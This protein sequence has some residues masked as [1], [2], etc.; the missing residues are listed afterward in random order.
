MRVFPAPALV[1]V[2]SVIAASA[3]AQQLHYPPAARGDVVDDY[4]GHH[5]ADPYRWLE[6]LDAPATKAWVEAENTLTFG[7]LA[8]LPQRDSI[9]AR[10]TALWNYPKVGVPNREAGQIWFRKNTGLQRQSVLYRAATLG[11]T[12]QVALDPNLLSPDGSIA[13]AQTSPSPDG[14]LLGYTTAV[15]GSDLQDIHLRDLATGRDLPDVVQRVKFTGI[16]WTRDGKGF[17]YARF[18]SAAQGEA[19]REA[20]THHQLWYHTVGGGPDRLVFERPDDSTAFVGGGVSDDGRWLFIFSASGTSNNRLWLEDLKDPMH[21]ALDAAPRSIVTAED[22]ANSPLGIVGDTL[23]LYTNWLA[24]R[25]RIVAVAVGDTD[26]TH[27]RTVVAQGPDVMNA[28]A[29]VGNRLVVSDLVDVQSRIRLYDLSGAPKGEVSLPD[30][31]SVGGLS[32]RTDGSD[33][34]FSFSS[35]LRPTTVYRY[36][37]RSGGLTPFEAVHTPFDPSPYETRA[38][39]Y[40]SKDGTRIPIFITA[41]RGLVKDGNHPTLLYA[42]G[43]FD[44]SITPFFSPRVAAWLQLGG[45]YAVANIRG[46]GEYGEA[47]HHAGWREKKQNVFD[48]FIAAGEFLIKQGYATSRTL[49]VQGGSNGGLLVGAVM[50]QRPELFAVALPAVGVMDMLRY[51]RFT[52]GQLWADEYGSSDDSADVGY[53]LAYSPLQNLTPGTCYPAT[54][55]TTADHDDRVVPGHSF[56]FAATLQADQACDRPTLIRIEKAGSHGYR[57]TDRVIAEIADEYAFALGNMKASVP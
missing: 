25:G 38:T 31:G 17:Y 28:E 22:A 39:F 45:V 32:G 50:T 56:K 24:E 33:F 40:Q 49:A 48:D 3:A 20:S 23:Y 34:F 26:R 1:A 21:P 43:G 14:R 4:F 53:L 10:L 2:L 57:P 30:V 12:P 51:Q 18:K 37:L 47:W 46:G 54:L 16:S 5:V 29:L 11:G 27:W 36:D 7:Y 13:V 19:L 9:R 35:Y 8:G 55:V 44:I 15:G 42:Y 52:G 41:R 6:D